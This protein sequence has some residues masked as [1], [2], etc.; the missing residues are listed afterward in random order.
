MRDRFHMWP[1]FAALI[2]CAAAVITLA[3]MALG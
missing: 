2:C 1:G 3:H